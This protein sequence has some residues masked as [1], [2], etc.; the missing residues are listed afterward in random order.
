MPE[1]I[2]AHMLQPEMFLAN[3]IAEFRVFLIYR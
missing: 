3:Q 2:F 1:E